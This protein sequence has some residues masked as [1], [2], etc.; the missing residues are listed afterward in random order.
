MVTAILIYDYCDRLKKSENKK[1]F[2]VKHFYELPALLPL[3]FFSY[4]EYESSIAA[5]FRAMRIIRILRLLRLLRL[6]NLFSMAKFLKANGFIYLLILLGVSLTFGA[7]GMLVVEEE[8]PNSNIKNF[9][10]ALWFS[11]TTITISGFGDVV[12]STVEGRVIAA[13]LIIVGLTTILGFVSSF[14]ATIIQRR[15]KSEVIAGDLKNSIKERI[16]ILEDIHDSEI[17]SLI[18]EIRLLHK[19]IYD[20]RKSCS[21]CGYMYP[22]ESLFCNKCGTKILK[23]DAVSDSKVE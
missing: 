7:I 22:D 3:I 20:E 23:D 10:D 13:I 2:L 19:K 1:K 18:N 9:G 21:E 12:P 11:F 4:I 16:D 5:L 8:N 6:I 17:E 14:G 15:L